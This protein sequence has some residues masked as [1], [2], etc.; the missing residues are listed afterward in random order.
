MDYFQG[1]LFLTTNRVG[2]FDEA[3][4]SRIHLSIGYEKLDD[5]AR[6]KIWD[7]DG[8]FDNLKEDSRNHRTE[9]RYDYDAKQYVKKDENDKS[10]QWNGREIRNGIL[11]LRIPLRPRDPKLIRRIQHFEQQSPSLFLTP[12]SGR[13]N[14]Q[15]R[16]T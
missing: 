5:R 7:P 15:T 4:K 9:I 11:H 16:S 3:F 14:E 13:R 10:L 1:I 8:L 6:E 12:A 2:Q